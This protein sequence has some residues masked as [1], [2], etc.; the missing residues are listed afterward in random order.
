MGI[1]SNIYNGLVR[2]NDSVRYEYERYV[3]EHIAEHYLSRAKHWK[4]LWKLKWHYEIKKSTSPL[5][6]FDCAVDNVNKNNHINAVEAVKA[7]KAAT[8]AKATTPANVPIIGKSE[9]MKRNWPNAYKMAQSLIQYDVISF[10]IFDTLILRKLN[11]PTDVFLI[12]GERVNCPDFFNIRIQAERE[13]R[14]IREKKDGIREI[15]IKEIYDRVALYT[16]LNAQKTAEIEFEIEKDV[17]YANE[18]LLQV[19]KILKSMGKKVVATSDM[20]YPKKQMEILLKGCGYTELDDVIVSCDYDCSK[21]D[22]K[23]W[24]AFKE[25]YGDQTAIIHIGDGWQNDIVNARNCGLDAK[26]YLA[27][28]NLGNTH[29]CQGISPLIESGYRAIVNNMLHN[30]S[31][32]YSKEWEYGFVYGGLATFGY[33]NWIHRQ[34]LKNNNEKILFLARDGYV[35]KKVY[36]M[37]YDDIPSEYVYWSRAAAVRSITSENRYYFLEHMLIRKVNTGETLSEALQIC[38]VRNLATLFES[39]GI[40]IAEEITD[41]N[42]DVI[43]E[44]L[45]NNWTEV[46]KCLEYSKKYTKEYIS[47]VI[48][49]CKNIG[50][51]DLGFSG[52]NTNALVN[53]MCECGLESDKVSQ[54]LL[55]NIILKNN[56][57]MI[58]TKKYECYMFDM[59]ENTVG[60][61]KLVANGE[62][63]CGIIE[64]MFGAPHPSFLGFDKEGNMVYAAIEQENNS[65]ILMIQEG[66]MEFCKEYYHTFK[67]YPEFFEI[68]GSDAY[69]PFDFLFNNKGYVE[70][71][72]GELK[73]SLRMSEKEPKTISNMKN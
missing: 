71:A 56:A 32:N 59:R 31:R 66:I 41:N 72:V 42:I 30:G 34:A 54:Y 57:D 63:G 18:Y 73:H 45:L 12:V 33:V 10:D 29:R 58:L 36:D 20:Y 9:S 70:Y 47:T 62:M 6:Y 37:L 7:A 27:C 38:G 68:S 14:D 26:H 35:F 2:K 69:R 17:C 46:E 65:T 51:V 13:S 16:G 48:G 5:I 67:K 61:N 8:P 44:I 55:G 28:R 50:L 23:L 64:K 25:K 49:E 15:T 21:T 11:T 52:K 19:Y 22:G 24:E 3:Q 40:N 1:K 39:N 4:L 60:R 53:V 43:K